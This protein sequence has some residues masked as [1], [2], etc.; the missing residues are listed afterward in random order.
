M[1]N[2][3]RN[4]TTNQLQEP[5]PPGKPLPVHC[6]SVYIAIVQCMDCGKGISTG[7]GPTLNVFEDHLKDKVHRDR[8]TARLRRNPNVAGVPAYQAQ[9]S[10][11]GSRSVANQ[12]AP[13]PA[14]RKRTASMVDLTA[15][16][17]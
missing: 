15:D 3:C 7:P 6:E 16:S 10:G 11:S 8:V 17:D 13:L 4:V 2:V 14:N 1:A 12:V 9:G 5:P